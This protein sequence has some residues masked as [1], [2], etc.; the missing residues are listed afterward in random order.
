V[1]DES[2]TDI[3]PALP[4]RSVFLPALLVG[5]AV[6]GWSSFQTYQLVRE[7]RSL[8]TV[9]ANQQ[10]QVDS[11][12]KLRDSLQKLAVELAGL[13]QA[14]NSNA[15]VVVDELRRRGITINAETPP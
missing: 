5:I 8:Q 4:A 11:S 2:P 14:G 1:S 6:T 7:N 12:A 9:I 13:A 3:S 15:T 10:T